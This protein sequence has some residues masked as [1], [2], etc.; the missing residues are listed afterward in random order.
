MEAT[1]PKDH[2][3]EIHDDQDNRN[4]DAPKRLARFLYFRGVLEESRFTLKMNATFGTPNDCSQIFLTAPGT[5]DQIIIVLSSIIRK[6]QNIVVAHVL[7]LQ[8]SRDRVLC[9]LVLPA[10]S[11]LELSGYRAVF[12]AAA[13]P[14]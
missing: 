12:E 3:N 10:N 2:G 9:R 11:I 14:R 8:S 6:T 5:A 13:P 7:I 4:D 1:L